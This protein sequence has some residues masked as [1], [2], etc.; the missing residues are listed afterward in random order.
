MYEEATGEVSVV[1]QKDVDQ[2]KKGM[3]PR[4]NSG[5]LGAL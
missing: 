1:S 3:E 4:T 2:F 5:K